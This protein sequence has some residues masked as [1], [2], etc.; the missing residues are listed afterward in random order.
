MQSDADGV[1]IR[2]FRAHRRAQRATS[3]ADGLHRP[4]RRRRRGRNP[5]GKSVGRRRRRREHVWRG[6][7]APVPSR[8]VRG[9]YRRARRGRRSRPRAAA[10]VRRGGA[11]RDRPGTG[12]RPGRQKKNHRRTE[13]PRSSKEWPCAG[14]TAWTP[15]PMTPGIDR[16]TAPPPPPE[17]CWSLPATG[18]QDFQPIQS[19]RRGYNRMKPVNARVAAGDPG[20]SGWSTARLPP[21]KGEVQA[22]GKRAKRTAGRIPT[23]SP[24][25]VLI[26]Q[27]AA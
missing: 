13:G 20:K 10:A 12:G 7:A 22:E 3:G 2:R 24:T 5:T 9:T 16:P 14:P 1:G 21:A 25:V 27:F 19:V 4:G 6:A 15:L 26:P 11:L 18:G 17:A 8:A 23:W